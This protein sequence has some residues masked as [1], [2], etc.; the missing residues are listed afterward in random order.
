MS[1]RYGNGVESPSGHNG[2]TR[3]KVLE[4]Y[5]DDAFVPPDSW[6]NKSVAIAEARRL[7]RV[8]YAG[9]VAAETP[10]RLGLGAPSAALAADKWLSKKIASAEYHA[11]QRLVTLSKAPLPVEDLAVD[12]QDLYPPAT[13]VRLYAAAAENED[14]W[15]LGRTVDWFEWWES[16]QQRLLSRR[17]SI[18]TFAMYRDNIAW[19]WR[20][21]E[22]ISIELRTIQK[23]FAEYDDRYGRAVASFQG[24]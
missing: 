14:A 2:M 12:E 21:V 8:A 7:Q 5:N 9:A 18:A 4:L 15:R 19:G 22:N 1:K 20:M 3:R 17:I 13:N 11:W 24:G 16:E 10:R 23:R 6:T